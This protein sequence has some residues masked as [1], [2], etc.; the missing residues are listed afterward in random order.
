MEKSEKSDSD[1]E[2]GSFGEILHDSP[3]NEIL[4]WYRRAMGG[5]VPPEQLEAAVRRAERAQLRL[6]DERV[7]ELGQEI[8][9]LK[10]QVSHLTAEN[11]RLKAEASSETMI[12]R[13]A[14]AGWSDAEFD[15]MRHGYAPSSWMRRV[16]QAM[17]EPTA[18]MLKAAEELG[19]PVTVH[20]RKTWQA[21]IDAA[22][23]EE[24]KG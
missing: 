11:A 14:R 7:E 19:G 17:R 13:M 10:S 6:L 3:S 18:A 21:M 23:A 5:S 1:A 20:P 12:E 16:A 2:R 4:D 9:G 22:L 8:K 15:L 24:P